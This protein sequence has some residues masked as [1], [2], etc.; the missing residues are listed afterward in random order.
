MVGKVEGKVL[1]RKLWLVESGR[2]RGRGKVAGK[3]PW[4][5]IR[6]VS[7]GRR[8]DG[9]DGKPHEGVPAWLFPQRSH[10]S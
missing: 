2:S 1:S 10:R 5:G 9:P 8:R 3:N 7:A 4:K 6:G